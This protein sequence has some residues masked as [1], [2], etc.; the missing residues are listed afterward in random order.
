[1]PK[2]KQINILFGYARSCTWPTDDS[3][4]EASDCATYETPKK[5][6]DS[7]GQ[8]RSI[9]GSRGTHV[10]ELAGIPVACPEDRLLSSFKYNIM[11]SQPPQRRF[12]TISYTYTCCKAVSTRHKY[13]RTR[14]LLN[15]ERIADIADMYNVTQAAILLHNPQF[16]VRVALQTDSKSPA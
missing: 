15:G 4:F 2:S 13:M 16:L 6:G 14:P 12:V 1:M 3:G 9:V 5:T 8:M 11:Q 7:D 10:W